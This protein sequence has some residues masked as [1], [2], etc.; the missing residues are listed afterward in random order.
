MKMYLLYYYKKNDYSYLLII[1]LIQFKSIDQYYNDKSHIVT[2]A[3]NAQLVSD[4][5]VID[6]EFKNLDNEIAN[7]DDLIENWDDYPDLSI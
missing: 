6:D 2:D 7:F 3:V 5:S 4:S 1:F